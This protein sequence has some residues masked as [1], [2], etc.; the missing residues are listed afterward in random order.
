MVRTSTR[1]LVTVLLLVLSEDAQTSGADKNISS[2]PS[3]PLP[4][5]ITNP[6]ITTEGVPDPSPI[7][8]SDVKHAGYFLL[9]VSVIFII[10]NGFL[11]GLICKNWEQIED[12]VYYHSTLLCLFLTSSDLALCLFLGLPIGVRLTFEKQLRDDES[13]VYYTEKIGFLLFEYLYLLR[14]ITV[15]AISAE[16]CFHILLPSGYK[17]IATQ[18]RVKVIC[19]IIVTLPLIEISPM[20]HVLLTS[21]RA[22]V[23]CMYYND[24]DS[25][26]SSQTYYTP[27]A[28]MMDMKIVNFPGFR[29]TD[30]I[31]DFVLIGFS[32]MIILVSQ[33]CI[34]VVVG[35]KVCRGCFTRNCV[36]QMDHNWMKS[37]IILL[38]VTGSF[39]MT[40]LPY[41]INDE[42]NYKQHFNCIL[43]GFFSLFFHPWLYCFRVKDKL[44]SKFQEKVQIFM[45]FKGSARSSATNSTR[46]SLVISRS[47]DDELDAQAPIY[48]SLS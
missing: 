27:L 21:E 10:V 31:V 33:I 30:I 48:T 25:L 18:C 47:E 26:G 11:F 23:H 15:A 41:V 43:L 20:I 12:S 38:L 17:M 2:S 42:N 19:A 5:I 28:C 36:F 40:N 45:S 32:W 4:E 24:A 22:R 37:N 34:L 8:L 9:S 13:L 39:V 1:L 7:S 3:S 44:I 16:R 46:F 14:V 6:T 35:D 29:V